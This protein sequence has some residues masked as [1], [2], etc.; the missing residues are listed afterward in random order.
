MAEQMERDIRTIISL[1]PAQYA[2]I[3]KNPKA[4]IKMEE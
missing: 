1:M 3:L 4:Y 2:D